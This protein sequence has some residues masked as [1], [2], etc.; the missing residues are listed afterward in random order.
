MT[1]HVGE[2]EVF[3]HALT[4]ISV[5]AV[6]IF[7]L[8]AHLCDQCGRSNL[9]W[10][11]SVDTRPRAAAPAV[12][13]VTAERLVEL[14]AAMEVLYRCHAHMRTTLET[15]VRI[16]PDWRRERLP[17]PPPGCPEWPRLGAARE[18]CTES[19]ACTMLDPPRRR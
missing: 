11:A 16:Y 13:D 15:M 14:E 10:V 4:V 1:R 9:M 12:R 17:D 3:R 6:W 5:V 18:W 8:V 2:R 7:V 19:G